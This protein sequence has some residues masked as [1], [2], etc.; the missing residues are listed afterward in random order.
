M[1]KIN[2]IVSLMLGL[3]I[4]SSFDTFA[5]QYGEERNLVLLNTKRQALQ[6]LSKKK[7]QEFQA[8]R[9]VALEKAKKKGWI[10]RQENEHGLMELQ[11]I[12]K[13]G[14]QRYY[15]THNAVA[16]TSTSTD[17]VWPGGS[18]GLS[19]DGSGMTVGIWDGGSVRSTHQEFNNTGSTRVLQHDTSAVHYHATHVAGTLIAGGVDAAAK[20][21]APN[22]TLYAWDWLSDNSEMAAAAAGGLLLSNHSYGW[23]RGWYGTSWY[24]DP[25]V[26]DQEDYLFGFYD[27]IAKFTDQVA[28]NAPY[29]LAVISAGNDRG[30]DGG[31]VYPPDGGAEGYDC[32]SHMGIAK[33]VLTVGAVRDVTAG[34]TDPTDVQM[35][36]YSNWGPADDGRIKP[37]ICGNGDALYS[38]YHISDTA[39]TSK[40]GTSMATPNVTASLLLLQE[41]Y[42][43]RY[44]SYLKAATLKALALHTA[45]EA[46]P[47]GP[48]YMFGWG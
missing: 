46:G 4:S 45:D 39:Y 43:E 44:G 19:L 18:V 35:L 8:N 41:H 29:Y 31:G 16:A 30:N 42:H 13:K 28:T 32:I 11:G 40:S 6:D 38:T 33:N 9:Q 22:A 17:K 23:A 7:S 5:A 37:D 48:D 34:Y 2:F 20:G 3:G 1:K 12:N 10:I 26:S 47:T 24:G 36:F 25:T 14:K 21:M 15:I 27:N